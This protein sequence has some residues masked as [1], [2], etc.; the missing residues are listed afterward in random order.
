[1]SPRIPRFRRAVGG[2]DH[3]VVLR[4]VRGEAFAHWRGGPFAGRRSVGALCHALYGFFSV[5]DAAKKPAFFEMMPGFLG[6]ENRAS[7]A[8]QT[9]IGGL[10]PEID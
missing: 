9:E 2:A 1:M 8:R 7:G 6:P 4:H 5:E 3:S 10:F